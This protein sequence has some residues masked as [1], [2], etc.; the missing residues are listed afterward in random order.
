MIAMLLRDDNAE[1]IIASLERPKQPS[2]RK[3]CLY[4]KQ[5][6]VAQAASDALIFDDIEN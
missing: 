1:I 6:L 4:L 2:G 3:N 5:Y